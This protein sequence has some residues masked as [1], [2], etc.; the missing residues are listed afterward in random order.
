[1]KTS[2]LAKETS[3]L[4]NKMT[5]AASSPPP[6]PQTRRTTRS[7]LARFAYASNSTTSAADFKATATEAALHDIVLG[8][9]DIE[10]AVP[11]SRSR[12]R[13]RVF[14][15]EEAQDEQ[16]V[17][18]VAAA[19]PPP[20]TTSKSRTRIKT[21]HIETETPSPAT[22]PKARKTRKAARTIRGTSPSS[23]TT[24]VE[25]PTDW[26]EIYN[27]VKEM[28]LHGAARNAAVDT[29]GCERLFHPDA[30]E[31]DRRFH[32]LIALMLSS[33][34][35]DTVNA[36]AM[37]RLMTELPPHEE[38]A[39]GGLCLEN[40]LAVEPA[41][42]NELIWAVGFH[43]NKTKFIKAAAIILRDKFNSDIPDTIEGLT[44]LPGVGPKM[45]YLCLSAAWD[46]TEGIGVD[47][48][49]HR[50]TNL[51]GWHKTTQ[52][53]ATRHALQSWLPKDKWREINWLLV[54]FGQ[55]VC[56]PVGRKCGD[57]ELGLGGLCKAAERKKV[58]E[59]RRM[60]EVKV[61]VKEE[62]D[63]DVVIKTEEVVKEEQVVRDAVVNQ[64]TEQPEPVSEPAV[65]DEPD[66]PRRSRRSGLSR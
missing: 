30:S 20:R 12:K 65:G 19:A 53:E 4:F 5:A 24:H 47:V 29:M 7:S 16:S 31:R 1:M 66:A 54:G 14:K 57:C 36:V 63:E 35:K 28:R 25:P 39:Q 8:V 42:L 13:R 49:V 51:W 59:G 3:A 62:E 11:D 15:E 32:I 56:L 2:K 38:G 21:E 43:N 9:A 58:N 48:H 17:T 55:T 26:L 46:R 22:P 33:Q 44:S 61:E 10:D 18:D 60:R 6:P 45:A 50:I 41:L 27:A 52:P 64:E 40:V 23:S 34:T 37:K